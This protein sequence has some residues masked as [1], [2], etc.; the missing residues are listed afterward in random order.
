MTCSRCNAC[1]GW[2]ARSLI[3]VF[4]LRL[5]QSDTACPAPLRSMR[6]P[7]S[8]LTCKGAIPFG[9]ERRAAGHLPLATA[10]GCPGVPGPERPRHMSVTHRLPPPHVETWLGDAARLGWGGQHQRHRDGWFA[11]PT[12]A[13][14]RMNRRR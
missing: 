13:T 2:T 9:S 3:R 6:N 4:A 12:R 5:G 7:P 14:T 10:D 1:P 8:S 11:R